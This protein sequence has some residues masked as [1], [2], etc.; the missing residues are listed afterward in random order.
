MTTTAPQP[1]DALGTLLVLD[2]QQIDDLPWEPVA[3]CT[4]VTM[5]VLWQFDSYVQALLRLEPGAD[6]PG[7]PHLAAHHHIWVVSG[8]ATIAG[9]HLMAGSYVHVPPGVVH[10]VTEVGREGC[11][12]LQMHRPHAPREAE[13]LAHA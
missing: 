7:R 9:R 5:K 1:A 10:E 3:H 8:S 2:R 6:I 12:L 11:L 4:G 13:N